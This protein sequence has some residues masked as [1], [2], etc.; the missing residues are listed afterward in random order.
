[1]TVIMVRMMIADC[2]KIKVVVKEKKISI[3]YVNGLGARV[4]N[5]STY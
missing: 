2:N 5:I 3:I 4:P 1:M